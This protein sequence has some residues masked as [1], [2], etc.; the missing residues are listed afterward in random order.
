MVH[1]SKLSGVT[2]KLEHQICNSPIELSS[3]LVF[4]GYAC[5]QMLWVSI[6]AWTR[7]F[8]V[9]QA[10]TTPEYTPDAQFYKVEAILR[11]WRIPQV[12]SVVLLTDGMDTRPYRLNWPKSTIVFDISPDSVFKR[13]AQKLEAHVIL[14]PIET[15]IIFEDIFI[16]RDSGS[17]EKLKELSSKR[18]MIEE[19]MNERSSITMAVARE[20]SG[21]STLQC[22]QD[23]EK[24]EKYL[25][26]LENFMYQVNMLSDSPRMLQWTSELR[27]SWSSALTSSSFFSFLGQKFFQVDSLLFELSMMLFLNGALLR[28]WAF[29]LLSKDLVQSATL[30]RRAAGVNHHLANEVLPSLQPALPPERPPE[31]TSSVCSVL[32]L[33]C[34]AEAQAVITRK[35]EEKGNTHAS[36]TF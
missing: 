9:C 6:R 24:L 7:A 25:P 11:P 27:K 17:L 21:G 19:S 29:V 18:R 23:I 13:A 15:K 3:D 34:L 22:E 8:V 26:L 14:R 16:A 10:Q 30:F 4:L 33:L 12:S 36:H 32:S 5:L 31:V 35:F 20:M 28:E 1:V 2:P